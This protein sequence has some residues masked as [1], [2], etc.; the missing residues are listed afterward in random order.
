MLQVEHLELEDFLTGTWTRLRK[1][2]QRELDDLREQNDS[3]QSLVVDEDR[4]RTAALRARIG[5]IKEL[6]ALGKPAPA[7]EP[8]HGT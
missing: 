6:L 5:L 8:D 7:I 3:P 2:L 4:V 1:D